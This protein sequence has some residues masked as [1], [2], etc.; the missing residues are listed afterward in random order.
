V[1]VVAAAAPTVVTPPAP[2]PAVVATP[3]PAEPGPEAKPEAKPESKSE[4]FPPVQPVSAVSD[5]EAAPE[6]A[7]AA[8]PTRKILARRAVRKWVRLARARLARIAK[9]NGNI[10][11]AAYPINEFLAFRR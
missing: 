8:R 4:A 5:N 6:S 7:S 10:R 1:R 11:P 2:P 9:Q 3:A